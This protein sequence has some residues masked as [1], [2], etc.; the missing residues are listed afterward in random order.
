M[1]THQ[2]VAWYGDLTQKAFITAIAAG[3]GFYCAAVPPTYV[4]RVEATSAVSAA[5]MQQVESEE[6]WLLAPDED[7]CDAELFRNHS[8]CQSNT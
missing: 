3:V 2:Y 5:F 1:H 8:S 7:D 6:P 4:V